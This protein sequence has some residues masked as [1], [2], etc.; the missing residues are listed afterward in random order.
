M[1]FRPPVRCNNRTQ[2]NKKLGVGLEGCLYTKNNQQKTA[3]IM[4]HPDRFLLPLLFLTFFSLT[5]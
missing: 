2:K 5:P 4:Q 1:D 3:R